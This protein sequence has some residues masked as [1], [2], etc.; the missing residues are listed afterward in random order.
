MRDT[1]KIYELANGYFRVCLGC[2]NPECSDTDIN[3]KLV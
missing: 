3:V 2:G 1:K